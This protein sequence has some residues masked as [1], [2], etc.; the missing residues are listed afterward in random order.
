MEP[1]FVN[2]CA[3]N[4]K[5]L[6]EMSKHT[7]RG[8]RVLVIV[9]ALFLLLIALFE[10]FVIY[11][12]S[13]AFFSLFL[14]AFFFVYIQ[15]L[16]RISARTTLKRYQVLYHADVVSELQFFEDHILM[17]SEQTKEHIELQYAQIKKVVRTKNL[18][19]LQ[20]SAQLVLLADK[21]G[22]QSGAS[23]LAFEGFLR[24]K[25]VRARFIF[26]RRTRVKE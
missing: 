20:L 11:D 17:Q 7:R 14:G 23:C 2:S 24:Q 8:A 6:V 3:H 25:A 26:S 5:N 4:K 9:C 12:F 13:M 18:Y 10:Y 15:L 19:L 22:F 21:A 16:P 1:K